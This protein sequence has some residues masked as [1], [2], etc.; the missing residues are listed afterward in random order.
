MES[1]LKAK[2]FENQ[3]KATEN[4]DRMQKA[5]TKQ[6]GDIELVMELNDNLK[7]KINRLEEKST[8]LEAVIKKEKDKKQEIMDSLNMTD[9]D[10]VKSSQ[11][12]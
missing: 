9:S 2:L 11:R 3:R 4:N 7:I 10:K 8:A 12:L 1:S 5:I 6:K